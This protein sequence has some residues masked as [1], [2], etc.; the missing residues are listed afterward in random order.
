MRNVDGSASYPLMVII[1]LRLLYHLNPR[2]SVIFFYNTGYYC[3][4]IL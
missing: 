2:H 1:S 3:V 4:C